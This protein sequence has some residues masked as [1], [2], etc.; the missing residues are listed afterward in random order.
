[1]QRMELALFLWVSYSMPELSKVK[2]VRFV[3][4]WNVLM[5]FTF[6]RL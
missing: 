2:G 5:S 3:L 4:A 1:M 6:V